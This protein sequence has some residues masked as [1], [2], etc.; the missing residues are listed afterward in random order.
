N[1]VRLLALPE[2]VQQDLEAGKLTIGHAR[3]LLAI[4]DA[5][6]QR[7]LHKLIVGK[8]LSV[9]ETEALVAR[10]RERVT[11]SGSH[12]SSGPGAPLLDPKWQAAQNKL[13]RKLGTKVTIEL[14]ADKTSGRVS[15]D[16]YDLD[17][18]NT[19]YD[20]LKGR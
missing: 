10:E 12:A 1:M 15:V 8:G 4:P 19:I 2:A 11:R 3:A 20:L 17:E 18:F 5:A 6:R 13:E 14:H 7:Y 9:R 16:F